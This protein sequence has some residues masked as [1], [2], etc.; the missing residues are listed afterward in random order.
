V[1][2]CSPGP[3]AHGFFS[4]YFSKTASAVLSPS[5]AVTWC[6]SWFIGTAV[7]GSS[8][9]GNFP[10]VNGTRDRPLSGIN[11]TLYFSQVPRPEPYFLPLIFLSAYIRFSGKR[12][13]PSVVW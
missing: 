2:F 3:G 13:I 7:F 10:P 5:A 6:V 9:A 12:P 4:V 1:T 11:I 8:L